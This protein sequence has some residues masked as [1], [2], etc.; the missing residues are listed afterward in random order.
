M[1][2]QKVQKQDSVTVCVTKSPTSLIPVTLEFYIIVGQFLFRNSCELR[3][4]ILHELA[5]SKMKRW[6]ITSYTL[7]ENV[8]SVK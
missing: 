1:C 4:T 7:R 6:G 3:V 5:M 2:Q 8:K